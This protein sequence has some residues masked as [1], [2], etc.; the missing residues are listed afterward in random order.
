MDWQWNRM[1]RTLIGKFIIQQT[2][3]Y[4]H[5]VTRALLELYEKGK[6]EPVEAHQAERSETYPFSYSSN[7]LKKP[8]G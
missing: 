8:Y 6:V 1:S 7:F 3:A 4:T 5:W 2:V